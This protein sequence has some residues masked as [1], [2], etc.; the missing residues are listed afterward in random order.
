MIDRSGGIVGWDLQLSARAAERLARRDTP[1]V[2]REAYW[3]ALAQAAR[4]TAD[5]AR[6][7]MLGLPLDALTDAGLLGQL[8]ARTIVR[9]NE[10][11]ADELAAMDAGW[12]SRIEAGG[13]LLAA[14]RQANRAVNCAFRLLD[15]TARAPHDPW[16]PGSSERR[17]VMNLRTYEE[18]SEMVRSGVEFCCGNFVL[19]ARRPEARQVPP[20]V[21]NAASILSAI[22]SGRSSREVADRFK[23]DIGL[24][25]RLL[26]ATRSAALALNR[27]L[28]SIHEAVMMLGARELY[29][30]LSVLLMSS[31]G[32][33]TIAT[34]LHET[35][36]ARGRLLELL[37]LARGRDDP[38]EQLFVTGAFSLLDLILNVPLE[39]ALALTPLPP[40]ATEALIGESGPWWP[41]LAIALGIER[42]DPAKLEAG[43]AAL[44]IDPGTA[45][46]ASNQARDWAAHTL[47]HLRGA[48]GQATGAGA[49]RAP[50]PAQAG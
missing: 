9:V 7:V 10:E 44:N 1:R 38:A 31:D 30:W 19:A 35:A 12:A 46:T 40:H 47:R 8:P 24:S 45:V 34:A 28:D 6:R 32:R 26:H 11:Q 43:C 41:Y 36:L 29:R 39:V 42:D 13:L 3:F 21:V 22:I 33:S 50:A 49:Q 5:A 18:V 23:A 4:E 20:L 25:H 48:E 2:L 14:P 16:L 15:A 37:A 27:P 17:V